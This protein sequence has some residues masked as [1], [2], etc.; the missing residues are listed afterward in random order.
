MT[1]EIAMD[2]ARFETLADAYG[3]D[4]RRWP[5]AE[6]PAAEALLASAPAARITVAA[7]PP[8]ASA[9]QRAS[10]SGSRWGRPAR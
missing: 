1:K 10:Q 3:A 8:K 4:F 9:P 7:R 2:L 5:A 6:R